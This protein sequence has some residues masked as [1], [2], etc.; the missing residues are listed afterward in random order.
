[1][2]KIYSTKHDN[3]LIAD[4]EYMSDAQ[5]WLNDVLECVAGY[6]YYSE[7]NNIQI[8]SNGVFKEKFNIPDYFQNL[9]LHR[10]NMEIKTDL[11]SFTTTYDETK[12]REENK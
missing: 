5:F 3:N 11:G 9:I 8:H 7:L 12:E 6:S 10:F 1:M 2:V 4:F